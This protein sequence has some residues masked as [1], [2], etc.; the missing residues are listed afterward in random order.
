VTQLL[1]A[2][3]STWRPE[4]GQP[5]VISLMTPKWMPEAATWPQC[6]LVMPRWS[7]FKAEPDE[8]DRQYFA[9]LDRFGPEKI[10]RVLERIAREHQADRLVLLCW[11]RPGARCHRRLLADW[12]LA[13]TGE[14]AEEI[15]P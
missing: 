14:L 9:Q 8:W 1:T 6:H 7:Y 5:V 3:Y 13:K 12:L 10:A 11:E 4:H 2:C 15:T